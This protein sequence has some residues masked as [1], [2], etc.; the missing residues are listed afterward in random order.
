MKRGR[1][2]Q[3]RQ[4]RFNREQASRQLVRYFRHDTELMP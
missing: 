1:A 2:F 4:T 3:V